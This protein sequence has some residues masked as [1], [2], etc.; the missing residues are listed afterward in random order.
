MGQRGAIA[1]RGLGVVTLAAGL[2]APSLAR[3]EVAWNAP[4][5]CPSAAFVNERVKALSPPESGEAFATATVT[6]AEGRVSADVTVND[7]A[8][9]QGSRHLDGESCEDIADAVA[10]V[11]AMSREKAPAA[12]APPPPAT[13]SPPPNTAEEASTVVHLGAFGSVERG[14]LG[15]AALGG[16]LAVGLVHRWLVVEIQGTLLAERRI[17][18][19]PGV[20][21]DFSHWNAAARACTTQTFEIL[22]VGPCAG[23]G[24]LHVGA[25][26]VGTQRSF[27]EAVVLVE[28]E[29]GLLGALSFTPHV[30][31][32]AHATLGVPL[33]RP[34]F[35]L[36]NVGQVQRVG[37]FSLGIF[38]GPEVA[39]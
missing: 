36:E 5:S 28:P 17:E 4:A 10:L 21:G 12:P 33:S 35:V 25:T 34:R 9:P 26:G 6:M 32:R 27:A 16:A 31:L 37:A 1:K 19:R 38:L 29:V 11:I 7:A 22:R 30:A 24:L 14:V 39:F 18:L 8:G 23:V 13:S 20:G 3:A 15:A 2:L